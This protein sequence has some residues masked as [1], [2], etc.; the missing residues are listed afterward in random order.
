MPQR[1]YRN[2]VRIWLWIGVLMVLVQ[3]A[4]GGITRLTD[5]GLSMTSW[6]PVSGALPPLNQAEWE[7]A[8]E[9]YRQYPEFYRKNADFT[10]SEFKSIFWWE[11]I[12]RNW[13][14]L[15]GLVFA[16]PFVFFLWKKALT[17][18][19]IRGLIGVM[20]LGLA[21]AL[22]G[23]YMVQSGM[24]DS[25]W[26]SPYRLTAHLFLA[27][28]IFVF[29]YRM[30][31]SFS[32]PAKRPPG[33]LLPA[34]LRPA[35]WVL[36]G[37]LVVQIAYGGL[38]AGSDAARHFN[39]WPSM[40]GQMLPNGLFEQGLEWDP[41]RKNHL[42]PAFIVNVQF[43]HR[44]LAFLVLAAA[45]W[46][47]SRALKDYRGHVQG[48]AFGLLAAVVLQIVLGISTLLMSDPAKI[49]VHLG[50]AHQLWAFVLVGF[51]LRVEKRSRKAPSTEAVQHSSTPTAAQPSPAA[52]EVY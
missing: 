36:A 41:V 8:F 32:P 3:V 16:F 18:R 45:G 48:P 43:V 31:L 33:T 34:G 13:A 29:L 11:Y 26:V 17:G 9:D 6:E 39:T 46:L 38:V 35:L 44:T 24:V 37:L 52:T 5:S 7:A 10:L 30:V 14:R 25:P 22:M 1:P 19:Q 40:N 51:W 49:Q 15:I 2:A 4:I 47:F 12:H 27:L 20:L 21:Q 28:A 42:T 23:W 50:V